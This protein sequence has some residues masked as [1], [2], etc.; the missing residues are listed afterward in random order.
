[1]LNLKKKNLF[2]APGD[3]FRKKGVDVMNI[4]LMCIRTGI[5]LWVSCYPPS[6]KD[7]DTL[8]SGFLSAVNTFAQETAGNSISTMMVGDTLW[9]F[10]SLFHHEDFFLAS[11]IDLSNVADAR[12]YQI[13]LNEQLIAEIVSLFQKNYRPEIFINTTFDSNSFVDFQSLVDSKIQE[14]VSILKRFE[15]RN[16]SWL[17]EFGHFDKLIMAL[18]NHMSIIFVCD[19]IEKFGVSDE[20]TILHATLES[21]LGRPIKKIHFLTGNFDHLDES[22]SSD[23]IY[24]I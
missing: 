17:A 18:I 21:F 24:L 8:I 3:K 4:Q 14:I 19:K 23:H 9:S 2:K 1:V 20:Y 16:K 10:S 5:P 15:K 7:T 6:S 13:K 11:K 22:V 12:K